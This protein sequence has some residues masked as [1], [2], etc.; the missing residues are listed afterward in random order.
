[1]NERRRRAAIATAIGL[2]AVEAVAVARRRGSLFGA[3]TVVRCRAGHLFTTLWIPGAS[4]K[5][6]RLGPWRVQR[7]PV[8]RHWSLVTPVRQEALDERERRTA[9]EHRDLRIP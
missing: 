5:A 9:A 2:T 1:M 8:G 6:I 7:C 4:L 3:D